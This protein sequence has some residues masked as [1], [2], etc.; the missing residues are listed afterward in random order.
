M[1]AKLTHTLAFRIT[2]SEYLE[3]LPFFETFETQ[4]EG[5]RWLLS[6]PEVQELMARRVA[7]PG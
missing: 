2:P 7:E 5:F 3:L 1:A 6:R 4:G